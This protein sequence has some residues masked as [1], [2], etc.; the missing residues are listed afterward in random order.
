MKKGILSAFLMFALF[1]TLLPGTLAAA[2]ADA[3]AIQDVSANNASVSVRVTAQSDCA[4]FVGLYGENGKMMAIRSTNVTGSANEQT[5]SVSFDSTIGAD[6]Y[7]K[8]FL[9]NQNTFAPLCESR[10][11]KTEPNEN[12]PIIQYVFIERILIETSDG[13][14]ARSVLGSAQ[15]REPLGNSMDA[16]ARLR[17][18]SGSIRTVTLE[19]SKDYQTED[20]L[21]IAPQFE[22]GHIVRI[23][24]SNN[25]Y[26]LFA[27]SDSETLK[28]DSFSIQNKAL[29]TLAKGAPEPLTYYTGGA[30]NTLTA[31]DE[32]HFVVHDNNYSAYQ[33]YV[34]IANT[35]NVNVNTQGATAY[36]YHQKGIAKL[37]FV[38]NATIES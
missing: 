6:V 30:V 27:L 35:P 36:I 4:L 32:T 28:V 22:A 37:V 2:S 16:A 14:G 21:Q 9:L 24:S 7:A 10:D 34:G 26:K 8:A 17:Y 25:G 12:Y 23:A 3:Y 13:Y 20:G 18:S 19:D 31:D 5:R 1:L 11:S 29:L 33:T 38:T 15:T